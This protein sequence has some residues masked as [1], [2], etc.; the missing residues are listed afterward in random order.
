MKIVI[1]DRA[2]LG[3][4]INIDVFKEFGEVVSYATTSEEESKERVKDADIVLTNKVVLRKEQMD[5]SAIKLICITATGTDNV[6]LEYAK[7]KNIEVK[8]VADYST[9]SVVQVAFA[10]IFYFVQKLNYYKTYVDN[11]EWEKS[12]V[13]THIDEVFYELDNKRVGIIGFGNIGENLAKKAQAFNCEVV[14]YSTSGRN[15]NPNYKRVE[16][17]ELL[18]SSD[19]ISIHCPLNEKTRNLL[20]YENM[21]NIKEGAILL[22]LGRGGIINEDDLAKII[23]E[24]KIYCGIDVVS[25]E[26]IES[27]NPLLKV[28]NKD[29]L[30][31]T[32][33]I[34]W[35]SSEARNRL[36]KKWYKI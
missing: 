24:E 11:G 18:E 14:Y 20:T 17:D 16:L 15:S 33:H 5:D 28:V 2:T 30:L 31:L 7:S 26:P 32:P 1:L 4:D 36:I 3:E 10:M 6:D 22:N 27:T 25:K 29:R 34:G 19:I 21:K 12:P 9:S 35:G 8:N 13:F 23:D